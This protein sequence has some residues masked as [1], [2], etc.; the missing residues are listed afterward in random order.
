MD[1]NEGDLLSIIQDGLSPRAEHSKKVLIIGAGMAGLVA[2]FELQRAGHEVTLI[3]ATSRVGGRVLTIREPF[4]NGLY[5]EAGAMRLPLGH[6]L[7]QAYVQKFGL[8]TL[9]FTK[10]NPKAF[11]YFY[12]QKQRQSAVEQTPPI[13]HLY[14]DDSTGEQQASKLWVKFI[15]DTA[16]KLAKD[17]NYWDELR[18]RYGNYSL[19]DFLRG[20]GWPEQTITAF[21]MLEVM[22]PVMSNSFLD[23]LQVELHW[24]ASEMNQVAGGMDLLPNSFLPGLRGRIIFNTEMVAL[25]YTPAQVTVHYR[26]VSGLRQA[27][28]DFAVIA[29]PFP[30]LRFVDILQPFSHA[31]QAAIRQLHYTN[32]AKIF[33][34]CRRRFWEEDD[35]IFGGAT[36]TDLPNRLIF[37]PD[38][39]RE[40]KQ[41]VLMA[42]YSYGE[43]ANHWAALSPE[44]R[45]SQA[46]KYTASIHPQISQEFEIGASKV[47]SE[48][49]FAGG[50]FAF[51]QPG[52][53]A[54]LYEA[55]IA[56]EGP[57][58]FAGEHA[59]LKHMWIEGAV[60]S[61]LRS[62]REIHQRIL[63]HN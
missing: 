63:A 59:S 43:E 1:S 60:E 46:L 28:G 30:A 11:T 5:A 19:Q 15:L 58:H 21:S 54:R 50:G 4:G 9:P 52:Q 42:S 35:G 33:L 39:G 45:V 40:T 10:S 48:D 16:G 41:G 18:A 20:Q 57:V 37:Y 22:E 14:F 17:G 3:E 34:K 2:A 38:Y 29:I 47:W 53:Q 25:D 32:A 36:V 7:T 8:R 49:R 44:E 56:P 55:I 23:A 31:K 12:G 13:P 62:A 27:S 6:R 51:F 24:T 61:G 26:D